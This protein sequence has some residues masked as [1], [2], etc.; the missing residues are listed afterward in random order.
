MTDEERFASDGFVVLPGL[1]DPERVARARDRFEPLFAGDFPTGVMPDEWNWR[2]G[3]DADGVTRQICNGWRADPAIAAIVLAE[4]VGEVVARI[5]GW[6]GARLLQDNVIWKPPAAGPLALH[7]DNA[8]IDWVE[9]QEMVSCW[10]ALDD[11]TAAGGTVE[12][13]RGSHRWGPGPMPDRFHNPPDYQAAMRDAAAAAG[14]EVEIVPIAVPAGSA[15]VHHGWLW[16]GSGPNR[17]AKPRRSVV[18]HCVPDVAAFHPTQRG[19]MYLIY[20]RYRRP[21]TE[22]MDEASFPVLWSMDRSRS[23][24]LEQ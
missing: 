8:Y 14:A 2:S 22:M 21:G 9:P 3:R 18:A 4:E 11:T 15:V 6:R 12:Y 24:F 10:I 13:V 5:A 19:G 23:P 7:Q 16:H 1:I 17:G 20:G